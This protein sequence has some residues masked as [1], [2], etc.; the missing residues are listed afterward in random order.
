MATCVVASLTIVSIL[1]VERNFMFPNFSVL[2]FPPNSVPMW[3]LKITREL[4]FSS[5][6]SSRRIPMFFTGD[7][8]GRVSSWVS[9]C[10]LQG[11]CHMPWHDHSASHHTFSQGMLLHHVVHL[12]RHEQ[13]GFLGAV[14]KYNAYV[15]MMHWYRPSRV[16][17]YVNRGD[18]PVA[19]IFKTSGTSHHPVDPKSCMVRT[20]RV[21]VV[22]ANVW[23]IAEFQKILD[24][25]TA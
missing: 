2:F 24:S 13:L 23:R 11:L 4:R 21:S 14:S 6:V 8:S 22:S 10:S 1:M 7:E 16:P 9:S 20:V 15:L 25:T 3:L 18:T 17:N 12:M 5:S 19:A